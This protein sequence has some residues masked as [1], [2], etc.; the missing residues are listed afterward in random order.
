MRDG[1]RLD[2]LEQRLLATVAVPFAVV[3]CGMMDAGVAPATTVLPIGVGMLVV[4]ALLERI[5]PSHRSWLP[6]QGDLSV[7]A[8]RPRRVQCFRCSVRN[9]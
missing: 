3:G 9:S 8:L 5:L 2:R 1:T 7:D 4:V 6:S